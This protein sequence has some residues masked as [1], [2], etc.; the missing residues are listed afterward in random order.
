MY[1]PLFHVTA[2]AW[3]KRIM[4]KLKVKGKLRHLSKAYFFL[5]SGN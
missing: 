4:Q 2:M 1:K 3:L 5:I